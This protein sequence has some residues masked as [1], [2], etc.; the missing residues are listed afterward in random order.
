MLSIYAM[1]FISEI[2]DRRRKKKKEEDKKLVIH[3]NKT[4]IT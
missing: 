3:E 4:V 2:D 1:F